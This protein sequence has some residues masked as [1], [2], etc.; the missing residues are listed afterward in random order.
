ME[1]KPSSKCAKLSVLKIISKKL[2]SGNASASVFQ[3][4]D[5][6]HLAASVLFSLASRFM[7]KRKFLLP[8]R[9]QCACVCIR[10]EFTLKQN[11]RLQN[12]EPESNEFRLCGLRKCVSG[13]VLVVGAHVKSEHKSAKTFAK[14]E[15]RL[16]F[17][18]KLLCLLMELH[19]I[20]THFIVYGSHLETAFH[21]SGKR[22]AVEISGQQFYLALYWPQ[23]DYP[24][25][26]IWIEAQK[27]RKGFEFFSTTLSRFCPAPVCYL[28]VCVGE[29]QFFIIISR[30]SRISR[31]ICLLLVLARTFFFAAFENILCLNMKTFF[32]LGLGT[33]RG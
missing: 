13:A 9:W 30:F 10:C 15:R 16:F 33:M 2:P 31:N 20:K 25:Q 14:L 19:M 12:N 7:M 1:R 8:P 11:K 21:E 22:Q 4:S 23:S 3:T 17:K 18:Y 5:V 28:R 24:S 32:S 29:H 6:S 27:S 26:R